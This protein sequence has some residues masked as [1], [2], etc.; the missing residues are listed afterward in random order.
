MA[1]GNKRQGRGRI[2]WIVAALVV[3]GSLGYAAMKRSASAAGGI[4]PGVET[5][6]A[7]IGDQQQKINATGIVAS[8]IGTQV[9]I[10]SQVTGQIISLPADVGTH[11]KANQIVAVLDSPS[12]QAQ[13]DQQQ[14]SVSA[15][16]ASLAQAKSQLEQAEENAGFTRRQT[17]AQ[18]KAADAALRAAEAKLDSSTASAKYQPTQTT[19][20]IRRSEAALSTAQST[21]KQVQQTAR[22]QIRQAQSSLD[23]AQ[24]AADNTKRDLDRQQQLL[25]RGFIA[26]S[27]VDTADTTSRQATATLE[28]M[29]ANLD[30]VREKT[31]ADLQSAQDQVD[32]AQAT[33]AAT[34]AGR[35]QDNVAQ[36]DLNSAKEA[37]HQSSAALELQ[38]TNV[39]QDKIR[40]MAVEQARQAMRQAQENVLSSR[41][42]LRYQ[43]AQKDKTVIRSPING[44]VLSITSQQG[45]VVAAGLSV[46]TLITVADLDRLEVR[47]YVDET[48]IERVRRNMKA[49]VRVDAFAGRVFQGRVT[50]IA[51]ASTVKD[52]VVTYETTIAVANP[53][54]LLRPDMT[55]NVSFILGER[56]GVML[57]PSESV[58]QETTRSIVYV[59]HAERKGA[60]RAET[61]KI[62]AGFDDGSHT[63]IRSGLKPGEAVVLTGLPL[64]GVRASDAPGGPPR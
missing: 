17:S 47:A 61:R 48:D 26:Q 14:F 46:T 30:I 35:L 13:V 60:E 41:A 15:A 64:L 21:V 7:E 57:V 49:E 53:D 63:E 50:K 12:I 33:L 9:K 19:A 37:L 40:L 39:S 11:V 20:N 8:Q 59:L 62:E 23:N 2:V 10:G 3:L 24:A 58:H 52:N 4:P 32:Q 54:R 22:Q 42:Q 31:R 56:K 28:S 55:T 5:A 38:K 25:K 44:T 45:E 51:S 36:A 6:K 43:L 34:Q 18:I 1:E 27:V 29:K 16:E